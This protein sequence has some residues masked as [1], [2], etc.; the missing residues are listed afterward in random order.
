MALEVC[1]FKSCA[2]TLW[3][4]R[5]ARIPGDSSVFHLRFAAGRMWPSIEWVTEEGTGT[6]SAVPCAAAEQLAR[7][8]ENA[9]RAAGGSGGGAFVINEFGQVLVPASDGGRRR[10]LVGQLSGRLV[11]ENPFNNGPPVDLGDAGD[12]QPGD[13]WTMPYIGFPYNLNGRS[14]IYFY[15]IDDDGGQSVYPPRQDAALIQALRC[16]RRTGAVRF[17]VNPAGLVLTKRPKGAQWSPEES[18]ESVFVGRINV[19]LWF[20]RE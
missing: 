3:A 10:F 12:L 18:W 7:A 9:K 5:Y 19:N 20:E 1:H 8:V 17:I 4:G 6:C 13:P 14:Q 16:V 15:R 2:P 11:F